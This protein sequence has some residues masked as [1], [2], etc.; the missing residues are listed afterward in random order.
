LIEILKANRPNA[1]FG[2]EQHITN[3]TEIQKLD[4]KCE[5]FEGVE[6]TG[7]DLAL[8]GRLPVAIYASNQIDN[9]AEYNELSGM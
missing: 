4:A 2:G 3:A 7:C 8:R 9:G 6:T 1:E 5:S